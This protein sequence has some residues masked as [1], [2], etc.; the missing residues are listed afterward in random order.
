M[1]GPLFVLPS[2]ARTPRTRTTK[3][4]AGRSTDPPGQQTLLCRPIGS[5]P[6]APAQPRKKSSQPPGQGNKRRQDEVGK[7]VRRCAD[8]KVGRSWE[9]RQNNVRHVAHAEYHASGHASATTQAT[10]YSER[11][12]S[13][14]D[15]RCLTQ[16]P[17]SAPLSTPDLPVARW[18]TG[19]MYATSRACFAPFGVR[20]G[21]GGK[22]N[23]D[24]DVSASNISLLHIT[25][26]G[27]C[28]T[29]DVQ[30]A[31]TATCP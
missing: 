10:R 30:G 29:Y 18:K 24:D 12:L 6:S 25:V 15:G 20:E 19:S 7:G 17:N 3:E 22:S 27:T 4:T 21:G 8:R 2:P 9:P 14:N 1:A 26:F 16:N 5:S 23:D 31:F 13:H 28:L 11:L